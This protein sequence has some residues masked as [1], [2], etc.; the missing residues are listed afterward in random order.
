MRASTLV[1]LVLLSSIISCAPAEKGAGPT[2]GATAALVDFA[3]PQIVLPGVE[4]QEPVSVVVRDARGIVLPASSVTWTSD[5]PSVVEVTGTGSTATLRSRSSGSANIRAVSGAAA[6]EVNVKVLAVRGVLIDQGS[7]T[8]RAFASTAVTATVD[9]EAGALR[10]VRW[11]VENT[12][13]A[14]IS[15][16][17][18]VNAISPGTT[19]VRAT[20]VGDPRRTADIVLTVTPGPALTIQPGVL[21]LWMGD[22]GAVTAEPETGWTLSRDVSWTTDNATI[23]TV[24]ANGVVTAVGVGTT[25]VRAASVADPRVKGVAEVRIFPARSVSITPATSTLNIGGSRTLVANVSIEQGLSRTVTWRSSNPSVV[26]VSQAGVATALGLGTVSISAVSVE[27]TLRRASATITVT[28]VVRGVG[29]SPTSMTLNSGESD[30]A[31][32][33]VDAEGSLSRAVT[34]RTSNPT[35]ATVSSTGRIV[36]VAPGQATVS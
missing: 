27:D 36:G 11:T 10:T 30:V 4:Q 5:N 7:I 14:T 28:P 18:V 35:I 9:A 13:I 8:L 12:S 25:S 15:A 1:S 22:A 3:S 26:S 32:A 29:V 21:T 6:S 19:N 16:S 24:N 23:A 2:Q 17:G 34:W 31:A 33:E 20:A